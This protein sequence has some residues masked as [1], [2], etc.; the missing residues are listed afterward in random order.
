MF[1]EKKLSITKNRFFIESAYE[2][3]LQVDLEWKERKQ[4]GIMSKE[5]I[6]KE[7]SLKGIAPVLRSVNSARDNFW[8]NEQK[9]LNEK[10]D[11]KINAITRKS[12]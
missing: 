6:A 9:R 4:M 3:K 7:G 8:V 2:R 1:F 11:G 12:V 10:R 5:Y